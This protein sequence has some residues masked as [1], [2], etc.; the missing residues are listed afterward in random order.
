MNSYI[1]K[2][3]LLIIKIIFHFPNLRSANLQGS[4]NVFT[5]AQVIYPD[6][7]VSNSR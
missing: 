6:V 3:K 5:N 4:P 7:G 2:N 1:T